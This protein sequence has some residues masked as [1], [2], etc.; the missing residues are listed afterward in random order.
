MTWSRFP[1]LTAA[2]FVLTAAPGLYQLADPTRLARWERD[3]AQI[4]DGQWYRLATSLVTQDGGPL[5]L[6]SN[7][8]FLAVLGVAAERRLGRWRWLLLYL[9]GAAVGQSA[10]LLFHTVGAGNSIAICGLAGGLLAAFSRGG[11][12]RLDA[13]LANLFVLLVAVSAVPGDA[14]TIAVIVAVVAGGL[15]IAGRESVPRWVYPAIGGVVGITLGLLA[16]L[17]GPALLAGL[18]LGSLT[19]QDHPQGTSGPGS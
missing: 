14:A 16:N 9:G 17:H 12:E 1:I 10:G 18:V 3:P 2:V 8:T 4:S 6:V 15:L 13:A 5:G 7:L 19:T 11:A